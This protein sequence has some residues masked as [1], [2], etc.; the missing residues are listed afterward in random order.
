MLPVKK[1]QT[2]LEETP[3]AGTSVRLGF[4]I[5]FGEEKGEAMKIRS[6]MPDS[7]QAGGARCC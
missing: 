2:V 3:G 4:E 7:Q 6:F 1:T 5:H